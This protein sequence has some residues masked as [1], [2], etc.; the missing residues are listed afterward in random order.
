MREAHEELGIHVA[1]GL[2]DPTRGF[3]HPAPTPHPTRACGR[4][5]VSAGSRDRARI[6]RCRRRAGLRAPT[7]DAS[8][9]RGVLG[10][11]GVP[12]PSA[13]RGRGS[14]R[15][16][17]GMA[18]RRPGYRCRQLTHNHLDVVRH[19]TKANVFFRLARGRHETSSLALPAN[20]VSGGW[21]AVL[22]EP[23]LATAILDG[24]GSGDLRRLRPTRA[25]EKTRRVVY[26]FASGGRSSSAI[27]SI[28]AFM[29]RSRT[30][31]SVCTMSHTCSR[32]TSAYP[33]IKRFRSALVWRQGIAG[34]RACTVG[35]IR[36]P[37]S[38][39][40][41]S[42]RITARCFRRSPRTP[43]RRPHRY[44]AQC[45]DRRPACG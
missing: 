32:C 42:C 8:V 35:S 36:L 22:S 16:R 28:K 19:R 4:T 15:A 1:W 14:G 18:R 11:P 3:V 45:A 10:A 6:R 20:K 7:R 41:S 23:V 44:S 40:I 39:M 25:D 13:R 30:G 17:Q 31:T 38:P 37:A 2:C 43:P 21:R 5:T 9:P 26:R 29:L 34:C 27:L 12:C 33:W 24:S